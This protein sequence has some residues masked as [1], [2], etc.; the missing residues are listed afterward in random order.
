MRRL[1]G[2]ICAILLGL[3]APAWA[4]T[5][6]ALLQDSSGAS[7]E[8]YALTSGSAVQ[9]AKIRTQ[10]NDGFMALLVVEDKAGGAGDVD[11]YMEYSVDGT[12]W[13]RPYVSDMA[14]AI[15]LEGNV[16]TALQNVSRYI[17]LTPRPA[18]YSRVILDP[19]ADSEVTIHVIYVRQ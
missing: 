10:D 19:D 14:G 12:N 5:Y 15:A 17:I 13:Y 1:S 18:P 9:S 6:T 8:N 3:A 11:I 7:I 16:V 2:L 4:T